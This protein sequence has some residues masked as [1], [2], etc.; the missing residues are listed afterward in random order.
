MRDELDDRR[1]DGGGRMEVPRTDDPAD[2]D[3]ESGLGKDAQSAI[4]VAVGRRCEALADLFL[5]KKYS[6]IEGR[7]RVDCPLDEAPGDLLREVPG[8]DACA[9]AAGKGVCDRKRGGVVLDEAQRPVVDGCR[10][11]RSEEREEIPIA[12]DGDHARLPF[13][14][15][16]GERSGAGAKLKHRRR[17]VRIGDR[18]LRDIVEY[19][20][21]E[22]E[23]LAE[24]L[25]RSEAVGGEEA[26]GIATH[27]RPA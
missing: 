21:I 1:D 10:E 18:D 25:F 13:E 26:S 17:C 12:L 27:R 14:E 5:Y 22:Q 7:R 23:V 15:D 6:A 11:R 4:V 2:A 16:F 3:G 24:A 19:F 8:E 20:A 9:G